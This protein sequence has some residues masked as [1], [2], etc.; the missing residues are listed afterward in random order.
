M[1][2]HRVA[3]GTALQRRGHLSKDLKA[4]KEGVV[5]RSSG[6]AFQVGQ[7]QVQRPW[8]GKRESSMSILKIHGTRVCDDV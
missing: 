6:R 7:Q 3:T 8:G 1:I 5:C 4:V 2:F